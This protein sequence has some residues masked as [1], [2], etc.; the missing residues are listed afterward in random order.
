MKLEII[1]ASLRNN[2]GVSWASGA[3]P[4]KQFPWIYSP[5]DPQKLAVLVLLFFFFFNLKCPAKE[6]CRLGHAS[7]NSPETEAQGREKWCSQS[8]GPD[9]S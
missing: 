3:T 8:E 4:F 1:G 2:L 9:S 6:S 5:P 7:T